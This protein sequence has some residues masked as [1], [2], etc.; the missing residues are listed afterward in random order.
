MDK[1]VTCQP[2]VDHRCLVGGQVVADQM[3]V[4]AGRHGLVDRDQ[5]LLELGRTPRRWISERSGAV[6][7][8]ERG[9]QARGAVSHVVVATPLG[10][11][12]HHRQHRL[13]TVQRLHPR[14]LVHAQHHGL[15]RRIVVQA[16]DLD[17]LVHEQRVSREL[18]SVAQVRFQLESAPD[19]SDR[20]LGQARALSH[21][22]AR[23]VRRVGRCLF[24]RRD[25]HLFDLV[26]QNRGR[27]ARP[28][29]VDQPVQALI[30]EPST[31]LVHRVRRDLQI[32]GDLLVGRPGSAHASTIRER[33][34]RACA[35][36]ARRDHR[37]S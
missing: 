7:D 28:R 5:K 15:L 37:T 13:R 22:L 4:Q 3:H 26:H 19:P 27:A 29:L 9:E 14:L 32:N 35:V 16:N 34:A 25:D 8:V 12:G 2:V 6:R 17:A 33:N 18:E 23:P 20:G 1:R 24:Q 36:F 30:H 21:R 11:P 10:H 31:P